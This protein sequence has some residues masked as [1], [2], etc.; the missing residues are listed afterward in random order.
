LRR[1][2]QEEKAIFII[3]PEGGR[4][5]TGSM[6]PFKHGLGMLVAETSVP[7]VPCGLIGTFEAL[8]PNRKLPRPV[9]IKLVIGAP[10]NFAAAPNNREGWSQIARS[11]ESS[12]RELAAQKT[13]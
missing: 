10:L 9:R 6:M 1:K 12:V 7:V 8:P 11:L 5:R 13:W 3:F 4:T 2:L